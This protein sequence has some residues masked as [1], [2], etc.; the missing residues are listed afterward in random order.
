MSAVSNEHRLILVSTADVLASVK[1]S[2]FSLVNLTISR[3]CYFYLSFPIP[4]EG[5]ECKLLIR[6]CSSRNLGVW[7]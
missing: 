6:I 1:V 3:L 4:P 5:D 7:S 2:F